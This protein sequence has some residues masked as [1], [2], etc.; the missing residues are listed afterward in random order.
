MSWTEED[1]WATVLLIAV[2]VVMFLVL[3][4]CL[5]TYNHE[6]PAT[7]PESLYQPAGN[8]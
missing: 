3:R 7:P 1:D 4:S 6:R 8:N 5:P 2:V